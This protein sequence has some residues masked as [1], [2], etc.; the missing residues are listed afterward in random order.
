MRASRPALSHFVTDRSRGTA[1][2]PRTR[3]GSN[4]AIA[5][6]HEF[7]RLHAHD[8]FT[9]RANLRQS[10]NDELRRGTATSEARK[11][12]CAST[13]ATRPASLHLTNPPLYTP[14]EQLET[15][16]AGLQ[17]SRYSRIPR[18]ATTTRVQSTPTKAYCHKR[19]QQRHR[20]MRRSASSRCRGVGRGEVQLVHSWV[21]GKD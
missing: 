15:V 16:H 11:P 6:T 3:E 18:F 1:Q 20:R 13:I 4:Y 9:P 17:A 10:G 8:C 12:R 5:A 21:T 7:L 14:P 19:V 2:V